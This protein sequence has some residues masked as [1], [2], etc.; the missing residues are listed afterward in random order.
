ME[1]GGRL[2]ERVKLRFGKW[3]CKIIHRTDLP[4]GQIEISTVMLYDPEDERNNMTID[5]RPSVDL[6]EATIAE[7]ARRPTERVAV[8]PESGVEWE[9]TLR[10]PP[11]SLS[12][13]TAGRFH[14]WA[15]PRS[16]WDRL[17]GLARARDDTNLPACYCRV[18][19]SGDGVPTRTAR[20]GRRHC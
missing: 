4:T 20:P 6:N 3:K 18:M 15:I 17:N 16:P 2:P 19:T 1:H 14:R 12:V 13:H 8:D 5:V 7:L 10:N 9:F 11:G